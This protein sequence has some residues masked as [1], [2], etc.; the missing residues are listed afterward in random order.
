MGTK[1]FFTSDHHFHHAN[2]LR[3]GG[4]SADWG[5]LGEMNFGMID[6]WNSVV[7]DK[8]IVYHLGDFSLGCELQTG[9]IVKRL[10]GTIIFLSIHWHH[11]RDWVQVAPK[12]G[13]KTASGKP[14][15]FLGQEE[16]LRLEDS[17]YGLDMGGY[18]FTIHL[19]HYPLH[20]WEG[21][22]YG[23]SLHLHGHQHRGN[24]QPHINGMA[25]NVNVEWWNYKPLLLDDI[26]RMMFHDRSHPAVARS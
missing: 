4:R 18:P 15:R 11:D 5:N 7:G 8:D 13:W 23:N 20:E 3:F 2:A 6:A 22:F 19:S 26:V 10:N 1:T 12:L 9:G 24:G 25:M 14:V 16:V 21:S 17:Q